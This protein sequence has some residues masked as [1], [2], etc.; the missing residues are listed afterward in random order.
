[1]HP[2]SAGKLIAHDKLSNKSPIHACGDS[3]LKHTQVMGG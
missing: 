1:M 2:K 3:H